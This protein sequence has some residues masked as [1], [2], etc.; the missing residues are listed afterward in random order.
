MDCKPRLKKKKKNLKP[1]IAIISINF[2]LTPFILMSE[3]W[4]ELLMSQEKG[5][6]QNIMKA[7]WN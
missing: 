1:T 3:K 6:V 2:T 5:I 7:S 4:N